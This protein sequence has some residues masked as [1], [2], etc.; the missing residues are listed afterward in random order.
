MQMPRHR[1]CDR[2][3]SHCAPHVRTFTSSS[4]SS[5]LRLRVIRPS[6]L[7]LRLV[8]GLTGQKNAPALQL[9]APGAPDFRLFFAIAG[10]GFLAALVR[11]CFSG[12]ALAAVTARGAAS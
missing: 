8:P 3:L 11:L 7:L 1:R 5:Y 9:K 6:S 10:L 12:L 2:R 4:P